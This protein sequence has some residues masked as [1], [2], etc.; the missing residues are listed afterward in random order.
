MAWDFSTDAEFQEK[1]DWMKVFVREEI[2]PINI[3]WP[4]LH[5]SPPAP[6]M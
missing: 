5:H 4:D 6:W 2:E 1:L 3:L